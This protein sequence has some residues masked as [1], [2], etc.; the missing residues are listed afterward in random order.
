MVPD[1]ERDETPWVRLDYKTPPQEAKKLLDFFDRFVVGQ[2]KPKEKLASKFLTYKH[3]LNK[4]DKPAGV[5]LFPG[6]SGVGKT[7]MVKVFSNFL[8]GSPKMFTR[9]DCAEYQ[10]SHTIAR[11]LGSPAGYVGLW[12]P[13]NPDPSRKGIEPQ[14]SQWNIDKFGYQASVP[15]EVKQ[16]K[17]RLTEELGKL[18][19][20]LQDL[21]DSQVEGPDDEARLI[22]A[23]NL[24]LGEFKKFQAEIRQL[25]EK[26]PYRPGG[27]P[28]ILLFDEI[29]KMHHE[30]VKVLL[31]IL[32]NGMVTLANGKQTI[33]RN[34]FIFM[35]S[36]VGSERLA[37]LLENRGVVGFRTRTVEK[38]DQLIYKTTL[39]EIKRSKHFPT[40][41]IGRIGKENIMVFRQLKE[42]EIRKIIDMQLEQAREE[43]MSKK[44]ISFKLIYDQSLKDYL[45]EE[46]SDPLNRALGA[47]P[48]EKIIEVKIIEP[49]RNLLVKGAENAESG[50]VANDSVKI[51]AEN[52]EIIVQRASRTPNAV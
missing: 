5:L 17:M 18:N 32:D 19:Q 14:L 21:K 34:C 47:R 8:F 51:L 7:S 30:I 38:I 6:P 1:I 39:E 2:E 15:N 3:G 50:I 20:K 41:L 49:V 28:A 33:L 9:I 48:V 31:Q 29:E 24:S 25:D 45:F 43:I 11:L 27:Y 52:N 35:T 13:D 10:E 22:S 36:N 26:Y 44:K 42:P 23:F 40:E 12:D 37:E 46:T 16:R 4:E